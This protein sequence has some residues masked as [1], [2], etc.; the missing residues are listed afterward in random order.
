MSSRYELANHFPRRCVF[1]TMSSL[2][3][4]PLGCI[5]ILQRLQ[6]LGE[7]VFARSLLMST[8]RAGRDEV[9]GCQVMYTSPGEPGF[10][11]RCFGWLHVHGAHVGGSFQFDCWSVAPC[12]AW[13]MSR[14][15]FSYSPS[16][17]L[18]SFSMK[19]WRD[20]LIV[21][22]EEKLSSHSALP[23][24]AKLH[25]V[26]VSCC[27]VSGLLLFYCQQNKPTQNACRNT[28]VILPRRERAALL[29]RGRTSL[30]SLHCW[31]ALQY[32]PGGFPAW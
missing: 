24:S 32:L 6:P 18:G 15:T 23:S 22:A 12:A 26:P 3:Q 1:C 16:V 8:V 4:H 5:R 27:H 17:V 29:M 28:F 25:L 20:E 19:P 21:V 10:G 13:E 30:R 11:Q 2:L 7:T 9:L 14:N 31:W